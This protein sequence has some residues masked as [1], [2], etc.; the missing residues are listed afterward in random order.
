[1]AD[2]PVR[3]LL[4]DDHKLLIAGFSVLLQNHGVQVIGDATT[5]EEAVRKFRELMPD[6]LVLDI[7]YGERVAGLIVAKEILAEF[8]DAKIVF[9]SQFDA[10]NLITE[11]YRIGATA[12]LT[13][14]C[15]LDELSTAIK[16][17][18][19]GDTYFIPRIMERLAKITISGKTS[20]QAVLDE[21][22][23]KVFSLLAAG[24]SHQETSERLGIGLKTIGL[25]YR[26]IMEKLKVSRNADLTRLA[27]E[28]DLMP[29]ESPEQ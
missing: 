12:F 25:L 11:A 16:K 9:L 15:S 27:I 18:K 1:M 6:V 4:A 21:R 26:G 17:S 7:R 3:V 28:Y 20:P 2:S 24:Y 10:D 13:K 22:E 29:S 23:L 14:D 8:P 19:A 5:P